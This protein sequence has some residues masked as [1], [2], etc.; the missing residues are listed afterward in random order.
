MCSSLVNAIGGNPGAPAAPVEY[1]SPGVI[2]PHGDRPF[3]GVVPFSGLF[4]SAAN[5]DYYR[6][7]W[8]TAPGGPW[9]PMPPAAAGGFTRVYRGPRLAAA[10]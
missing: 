9:N 7:E 8:A 5:V 3:A 4:G 2:A 1:L 6:F 10:R